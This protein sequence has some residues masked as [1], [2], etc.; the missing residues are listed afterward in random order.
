[1]SLKKGYGPE[2]FGEL[3]AENYDAEHDPGTTEEAVAFIAELARTVPAEERAKLLELAIGTGRIALPLVAM[4]FEVEGVEASPLM[5]EKLREK[6]NGRDISVAIADMADFSLEKRFDH[7]FLVFNTLFNL[8]TQE[9]QKNCFKSVAQHLKPGGSFLVETF[10]PNISGFE[11]G[12]KMNGRGVD[13]NEAFFEIIKHDAVT[14]CFDFQRI[15]IDENGTRIKPL[16][17]RYAWPQEMDLMA[18]LAGLKLTQRFG[19]WENEPFTNDSKM[20]VSVYRKTG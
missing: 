6:P 18:E 15:R 5:V 10:V 14:Q 20:H 8:T 13:L 12:F 19:G 2:T 1:M 4:G 16:I 7:A 9:A 11:N 17:M 3:N